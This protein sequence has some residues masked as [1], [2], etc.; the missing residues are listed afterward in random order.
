MQIK[1]NSTLKG[2]HT[3][4]EWDLPLGCKNCSFATT[5]V[6]LEDIILN[7]ISLSQKNKYG[8]IPLT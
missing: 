4:T 5:W 1:Y 6:D 7:E 3:T 8:L 2:S